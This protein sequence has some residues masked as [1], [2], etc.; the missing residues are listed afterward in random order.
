M[1]VLITGSRGQLGV[2]LAR[3]MEPFATVHAFDLPDLDICSASSVSSAVLN[4][5]PTFI[6]NA[7]AYTAV[8]M[9]EQEPSLAHAVNAEGPRIL[10]S[11]AAQC[12]AGLVHF[13]TDYV[14]DGRKQAPYLESDITSPL[15]EYGRSK[16]AGENAVLSS[17]APHLVLRSS[18]IYGT[19]GKN[20]LLT[21]L[22]LASEREELAVV[23]DQIGA[24]TWSRSLAEATRDILLNAKNS[25]GLRPVSG[26]YHLTA[27]GQTSWCGFA[28]AMF[29]EARRLASQPTWMQQATGGRALKVRDVRAITTAEYP[30]PAKRPAWSMLS[31][32]K[33]QQRLGI[34][35][36]DWR[37]QL[38]SVMTSAD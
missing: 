23:D 13:S 21:M 34:R 4:F 29:D 16:L 18:W 6:I 28:R 37:D 14:F 30:L 11:A 20:F 33:I 17:A 5:Q 19:H 36:S 24:P 26:L 31:N 27:A 10:A 35:L 2:E 3:A 32:G 38:H 25:A 9:A 1:K 12:G 7:A 15:G 8:D 22:R